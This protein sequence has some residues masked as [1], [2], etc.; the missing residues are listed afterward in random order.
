MSTR[1]DPR[2]NTE[3]EIATTR[4]G[5]RLATSIGGTLT[6]RGGDILII[7]D[8]LKPAEAVSEAERT[9]VNEWYDTTLLSRL[10]DK[11][12]G[13]VILVM[14]RLHAGDLTDHLLAKGG[15]E[16]LSLPAIAEEDERIAI[17]PDQYQE[18]RAGEALHPERESI[19]TLMALKKSIGSLVFASQY[20]Q[21]PIPR[22]GHV[23]KRAFLKRYTRAPARAAFE[24]V[25]ISWDTAAKVGQGHDYSVGTVWGIKGRD[26]YLLDVERGRWTFPALERVVIESADRWHAHAI[27]IEDA[28]SGMALIQSLEQQTR[29]NVIAIKPRLEKLARA[30]QQSATIEAGRVFIPAEASWL[31]AFE[32]ELLGFPNARHD[33]QVDSVVQF[34]AWAREREANEP[35]QVSPW[36]LTAPS[37]WRLD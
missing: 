31:A 34:L 22:E 4:R 9:R 11:A 37:L 35:P 13:L 23:F 1:I 3:S 24:Q 18:R 25:V 21:S 2:K 10:D 19:E 6:G 32:G 20:L 36:G 14:Q 27:L 28:N 7:D 15:F 30:S 29:L 8:P 12:H 26:F 16:L 17:G 5:F 33:D